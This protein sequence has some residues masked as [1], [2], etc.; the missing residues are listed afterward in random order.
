ML[1]IVPYTFRNFRLYNLHF[2]I[3]FFLK[4]KYQEKL[5]ASIEC[6]SKFHEKMN[7][8]FHEHLVEV[9]FLILGYIQCVLE[10]YYNSND[11]T[12]KFI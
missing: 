8:N 2:L 9:Q 5:I 7:T 11:T 10:C 6:L 4:Q 3:F 1:L 12:K